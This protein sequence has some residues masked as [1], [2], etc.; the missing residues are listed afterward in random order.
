[1]RRLVIVVA[2]IGAVG[3]CALLLKSLAFEVDYFPSAAELGAPSWSPD[4]SELVFHI[5]NGG[6]SQIY[7]VDSD[8]GDFEQLTS[9]EAYSRSPAWSP[10]GSHIA[11]SR[12][13]GL[14]YALYVADS[15]GSHARRIF[16]T[17]VSID[18]PSWSPDGARIAF[19][20]GSVDP[21]L[22]SV[23]HLVTLRADGRG[24][25]ELDPLDARN[26]TWSPDGRWIAFSRSENPVYG[27]YVVPAEG[28]RE[29]LVVKQAS[30]PT[31]SQ[32]GKR[33]AVSQGRAG[34]FVVPLEGG[35]PRRLP[36]R[37]PGEYGPDD[38][39]W[40]PDGRRIAFVTN[41]ALYVAD[42]DGSGVRRVATVKDA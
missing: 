11:F 29:R 21:V 14:T 5:E 20:T 4:G 35:G 7:R 3:G 25:R 17:D 39:A 23:G 15:D 24:L 1:M 37:L 42:V 12:A 8:G 36:I 9:E 27:V 26:P 28:G 6:K 38:L 30:D 16:S 41:G 2:A 40:S 34:I 13:P 22:G 10:D 32:D 31:W 33:L 19:V 18:G